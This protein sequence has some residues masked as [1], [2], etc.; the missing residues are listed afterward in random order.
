MVVRDGITVRDVIE[1]GDRRAIGASQHVDR[2][3]RVEGA[4]VGKIYVRV[5]VACSWALRT[6][7]HGDDEHEEIR[8]TLPPAHMSD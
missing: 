7:R 3:R 2:R 8:E 1:R 6:A 5:A 4:I